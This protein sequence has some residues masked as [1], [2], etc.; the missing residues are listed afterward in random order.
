MRLHKLK[1]RT[2]SK[3]K[4]GQSK[5][6][7]GM[8]TNSLLHYKSKVHQLKQGLALFVCPLWVSWLCA[9]RLGRRHMEQ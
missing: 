2:T 9:G 6:Y 1:K 8:F 5:R 4:Y 7:F 3:P